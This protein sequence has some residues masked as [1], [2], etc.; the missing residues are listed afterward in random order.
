MNHETIE[1][2][3]IIIS[4]LA[5]SLLSATAGAMLSAALR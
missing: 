1:K 3:A 4:I 5:A 2:A